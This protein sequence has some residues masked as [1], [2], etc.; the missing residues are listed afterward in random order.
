[1]SKNIN[2]SD[3]KIL[4]QKAKEKGK[5]QAQKVIIVNKEGKWK[6]STKTK[7]YPSFIS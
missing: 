3:I 7:N 6:L 1:M 2:D 4:K 5:L